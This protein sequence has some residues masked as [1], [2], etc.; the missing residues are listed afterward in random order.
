M[1]REAKLE[2][3]KDLKEF[4]Q[5]QS[6]QTTLHK[7]HLDFEDFS[8]EHEPFSDFVSRQINHQDNTPDFKNLDRLRVVTKMGS[9]AGSDS[10]SSN[11]ARKEEPIEMSTQAMRDYVQYKRQKT[12]QN[13]PQTLQSA[14]K[15]C[16]V[17]ADINIQM[18]EKVLMRMF[19]KDDFKNLNVAGQFN[20]GFI[21]ATLN[22]NDLFILDQHASDEK[23]NFE[24]FSKTTVIE[25]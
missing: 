15:D 1:S 12:A 20:K 24:T 14:I 7:V 23:F 22:E 13:Q 2:L 8:N 11:E 3:N 17:E 10:K 18:D 16:Q 9:I 25:A 21:M 6:N 19:Q 5:A 4:E